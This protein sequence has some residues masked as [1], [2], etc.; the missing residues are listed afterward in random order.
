M[1]EEGF[2]WGGRIS[3]CLEYVLGEVPRCFQEES[4]IK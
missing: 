4:E 3:L 2:D 1:S